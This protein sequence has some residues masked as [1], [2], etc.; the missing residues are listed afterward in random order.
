MMPEGS[1]GDD[2][3]RQSTVSQ[4]LDSAIPKPQTPSAEE[5]GKYVMADVVNQ[6]PNPEG[7][8]DGEPQRDSKFY[9][10]MDSFQTAPEQASSP[11]GKAQVP[12]QHSSVDPVEFEKT[13]NAEALSK[14]GTGSKEMPDEGSSNQDSTPA[15]PRDDDSDPE[16]PEEQKAFQVQAEVYAHPPPPGTE[17]ESQVNHSST[18][19][20][21]SDSQMNPDDTNQVATN[22]EKNGDK[23]RSRSFDLDSPVDITD[24]EK[25]TGSDQPVIS[26]GTAGLTDSPRTPTKNP[27]SQGSEVT[28]SDDEAPPVPTRSWKNSSA[29]NSTEH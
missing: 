19:G 2:P 1:H 26:N 7:M 12:E 21:S 27:D 24:A 3:S 22:P 9:G 23:G 5:D 4:S 16:D 15:Q 20:P 13:E 28:P 10:S 8:K 17:T 29:E 18:T 14:Q 11:A 6:S 25:T